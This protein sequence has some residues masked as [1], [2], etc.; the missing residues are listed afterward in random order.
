MKSNHYNSYNVQIIFF[1]MNF[2]KIHKN[3][4]SLINIIYNV[5]NNAEEIANITNNSN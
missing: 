1:N 4:I 5:Q 3:E 2:N